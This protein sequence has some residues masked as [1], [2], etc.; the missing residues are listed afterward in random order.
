[1]IITAVPIIGGFVSF[2]IALWG[3]GGLAVTTKQ[4]R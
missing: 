2:L 3:V 1:M 4:L